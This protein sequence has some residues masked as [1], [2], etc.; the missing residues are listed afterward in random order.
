MRGELH[1]HEFEY[2][3]L[4]QPDFPYFPKWLQPSQVPWGLV[5]DCQTAGLTW[6]FVNSP[7]EISSLCLK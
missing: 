4:L 5:V 6:M 7:A 1:P 2:H 3:P